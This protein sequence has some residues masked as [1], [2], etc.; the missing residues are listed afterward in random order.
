MRVSPPHR[1]LHDHEVPSRACVAL[2]LLFL[3]RLARSLSV[4]TT[5]LHFE[6]LLPLVSISIPIFPSQCLLS[7]S[8][9]SSLPPASLLFPPFPLLVHPEWIFSLFT[10]CNVWE[11]LCCYASR[12]SYVCFIVT[13]QHLSSSFSLIAFLCLFF[14]LTHIASQFCLSS[15]DIFHFILCSC[16]FVTFFCFCVFVVCLS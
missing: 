12:L 4:P 15:C 14:L 6:C 10:S 16:S 2:P 5:F 9:S 11:F 7:F 1:G 8:T 13:L 3:P